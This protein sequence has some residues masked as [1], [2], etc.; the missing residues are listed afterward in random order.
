MIP[1]GLQNFLVATAIIIFSLV[2][3]WSI[4]DSNSWHPEIPQHNNYIP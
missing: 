4:Q 3:V 2:F 1:Q